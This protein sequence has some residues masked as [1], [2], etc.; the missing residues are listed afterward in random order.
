MSH[1][2]K[3][4]V[5][6]RFMSSIHVFKKSFLYKNDTNF[7]K[8]LQTAQVIDTTFDLPKINL[9]QR[10]LLV[11]SVPVES[12]EM[13]TI[14][15]GKLIYFGCAILG[16]AISQGVIVVS[17][18]LNNYADQAFNELHQYGQIYGGKGTLCVLRGDKIGYFTHNEGAILQVKFHSSGILGSINSDGSFTTFS[19]STNLQVKCKIQIKKQQLNCFDWIQQITALGDQDGNV[20]IVK[21]LDNSYEIMNF[22]EQY[23]NG[24][25]KDLQFYF[26]NDNDNPLL[27]SGGYDGNIKIINPMNESLIFD[28]HISSKGVTQVKWDVGGKFIIIINDDPNQRALMF[29]FFSII[30]KD[31]QQSLQ[32]VEKRMI[33][34]LA[35]NDLTQVIYLCKLVLWYE[36]SP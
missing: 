1:N 23:H 32:Y 2:E 25:V 26:H 33:S 12:G 3:K 4:K 36:Q 16:L 18:Q 31:S 9:P 21:L 6:K 14:Q 34:P 35:G 15:G 22:L 11:D 30:K 28:K 20:Y 5:P 7:D 19:L 24:I 13:H 8:N 17:I 10:Y 29:T 27:L